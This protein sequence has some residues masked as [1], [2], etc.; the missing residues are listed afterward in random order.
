MRRQRNMFQM[1]AQ[2]KAPEQQQQKRLKK[3]RECKIS[4]EEKLRKL[5]NQGDQFLRISQFYLT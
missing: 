5:W 3:S 4:G 2:D 1:K